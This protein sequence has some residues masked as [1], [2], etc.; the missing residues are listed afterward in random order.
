MQISGWYFN[1][2]SASIFLS[3]IKI[4]KDLYFVLF[5]WKPN[6]THKIWWSVS[7]C[8]SVAALAMAA[9]QTPLYGR[10]I[11]WD[12]GPGLTA[13]RQGWRQMRRGG[14]AGT[15]YNLRLWPHKCQSLHKVRESSDDVGQAIDRMTWWQSLSP[16][17]PGWQRFMILDID[18][19]L[20]GPIK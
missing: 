19:E 16:G 7:N 20:M 5:F 11:W 13:R 17:W 18:W 3:F 6:I 12:P 1:Q 8:M 9:L 10:F 2:N 4:L 15:T 14:I